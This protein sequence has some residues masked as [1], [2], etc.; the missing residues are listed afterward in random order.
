[1]DGELTAI[2]AAAGSNESKLTL[3]DSNRHF[4]VA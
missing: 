2:D 3:L 4:D 1:M